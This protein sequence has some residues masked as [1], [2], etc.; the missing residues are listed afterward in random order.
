MLQ[1]APSFFLRIL[2]T[3][4]SNMFWSVEVM[5]NVSEPE[6]KAGRFRV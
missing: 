6:V 2:P 3:D 5:V 1:T 4:I